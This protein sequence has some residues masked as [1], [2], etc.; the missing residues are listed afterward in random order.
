PPEVLLQAYLAGIRHFG[1]NYLQEALAKQQ[2][3]GH[4]DIT[5]HFIGPIQ[6]NKTRAIASRFHWVH[7]VD[8]LKVAHRL[9]QQRPDWLPP[10][11][12]CL[13]VNISGEAS[14][15]GVRS[16]EVRQLAEAVKTLPRLKLRGLMAIPA[17]AKDFRAQREPFQRMR[18]IFEQCSDLRLDTLSMGMSADLEAAILEGANMVRIGSALFG[19]RP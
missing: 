10:L 6:A 11:N 3:L 13:Q 9:S 8:R 15:S 14:K 16:E 18:E 4:C 12:V 5:W 1:E 17:L 7:S 19:P 2:A